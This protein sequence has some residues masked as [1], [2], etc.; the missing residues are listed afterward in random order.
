MFSNRERAANAMGATE[1]WQLNKMKWQ[2]PEN[3]QQ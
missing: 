1:K 2:A 3:G